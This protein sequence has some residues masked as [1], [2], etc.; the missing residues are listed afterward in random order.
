[1]R[2]EYRE[3][4]AFQGNSY[5]AGNQQHPVVVG[6]TDGGYSLV[7]RSDAEDG[8]GQG[9]FSRFFPQ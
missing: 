6:Q 3:N 5:T 9:V 8:S 4:L 7:W 1:M 2:G